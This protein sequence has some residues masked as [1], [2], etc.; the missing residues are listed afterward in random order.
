MEFNK[1]YPYTTFAKRGFVFYTFLM[2][3][4]KNTIYRRYVKYEKIFI[5]KVLSVSY[6]VNIRK[7]YT[8]Q[9]VNQQT[10]YIRLFE[11]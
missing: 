4:H 2:Y 11:V 3:I 7:T 10:Y 1:I 6:T 5:S 8:T 9:L